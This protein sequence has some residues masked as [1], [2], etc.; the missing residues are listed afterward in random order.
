VKEGTLMKH[1][2]MVLCLV[3]FVAA[4]ASAGTQHV[5]P[6]GT[7]D[8]PTIRA[9]I[10]SA[11]VAIVM[12]NMCTVQLAFEDFAVMSDGWYPTN[13]ASTTPAGQTVED[14]CPDVDDDG[15]GDWPINP[16]TGCNSVFTWGADP[17][18]AGDMGANPANCTGYRIEG[19]DGDGNLLPFELASAS[20]PWEPGGS[21]TKHGLVQSHPNPFSATTVIQYELS[22]VGPVRLQV[23]D[24]RGR[25]VRTL[26]N[27]V[28]QVGQFQVE[29]NG[30]DD[31]GQPI[32][33]GFYFCRFC[34]NGCTE[35][36]RIVLAK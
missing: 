2:S 22:E 32:A 7:G 17:C 21:L 4:G 29:W 8:A 5:W 24:T 34:S 20:V 13:A 23:Y 11:G 26:V 19:C 33:P 14:L 28:G 9:W 30:L 27:G 18:T 25:L 15:M 12:A 10:D 16:F 3:L 31:V 1:L 6:D 36:V 35:T